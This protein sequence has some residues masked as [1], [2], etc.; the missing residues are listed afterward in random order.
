MIYFENHISLYF[1]KKGPFWEWVQCMCKCCCR[2]VLGVNTLAR[3]GLSL[4]CHMEWIYKR[5][6]RHPPLL[7]SHGYIFSLH[8]LF[9]YLAI[10]AFDI[11]SI[12]N[13]TMISNVSMTFHYIIFI[14]YIYHL[15]KNAVFFVIP[16][17]KV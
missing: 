15:C 7:H 11:S 9:S 3:E 6:C 17:A 13:L 10:L 5:A 1:S 4:C 2:S 12:N 8:A 14:Y 16:V